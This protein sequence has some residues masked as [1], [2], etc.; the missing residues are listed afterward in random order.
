MNNFSFFKYN[1]E[2]LNQMLIQSYE[3]NIGSKE[4]LD[5]K[6]E[7]TKQKMKSKY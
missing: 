2:I 4:H 5:L 7:L 6:V 3:K 1:E